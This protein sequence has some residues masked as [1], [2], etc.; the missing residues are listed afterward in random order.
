M[1]TASVL[2]VSRPCSSISGGTSKGSAANGS[3]RGPHHGGRT[4]PIQKGCHV[5][6]ALGDDGGAHLGSAAAAA[7]TEAA[8]AAAAAAVVVAVV[9]I[10]VL[11]VVA[12]VVVVVFVVSIVNRKL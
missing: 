7:A 4:R 1:A 3:R 12:V 11:V 8:A 2:V 6:Q 10:V 5:H 9:V